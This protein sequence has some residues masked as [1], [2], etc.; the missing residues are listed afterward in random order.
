[1]L[2]NV[3]VDVDIH[4]QLLTLSFNAGLNAFY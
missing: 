4:G 2:C 3:L 1:L